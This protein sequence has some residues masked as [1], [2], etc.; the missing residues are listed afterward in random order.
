MLIPGFSAFPAGSARE[1]DSP[2]ET[3]GAQGIIGIVCKNSLG[4]PAGK[5]YR[6]GM[7]KM[8]RRRLK[9]LKM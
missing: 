2:A 9:T 8:I 1:N 7:S 4:S 6:S 5:D 3:Q